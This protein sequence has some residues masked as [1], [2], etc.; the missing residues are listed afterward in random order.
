MKI[1]K[2]TIYKKIFIIYTFII[3]FLIISLDVYF[4]KKVIEHNKE[5]EIYLSERAI[6]DVSEEMRNINSAGNLCIDT[7]YRDYEYIRDVTDFLNMDKIEY[8]KNKL[9]KFSE[10]K[11]SF[12]KGIQYFTESSFYSNEA[13]E[14]ISFIS[15]SRKEI[16]SFN[17]KNQISVKKLEN[18]SL[19]ENYNFTNENN[20]KYVNYSKD[21]RN[22]E[23]LKEEGKVIFTYNLKKIQ[24]ILDKYNNKFDIK[25]LDKRG[26]SKYDSKDEYN[27]VEYPY[28]DRLVIGKVQDNLEKGYYVSSISTSD[29]IVLGRI[30]SKE[31]NTLSISFYTSLMFIDIFVFLIGELLFYFKFKNL[32]VR[33]DN[34]LNVMNKVKEGNVNVSIPIGNEKDEINLIAQNF[35]DMC[36]KL[37]EHIK[38]SYLSE[39]KEKEAELNQKKAEMKALQSQINPHFLYNTLE[40]IRMKAICNEDKEVGKMLYILAFL[41]RSQL[42]EKDVILIKNELDYCNK[43]LEIFK[44]RYDEKFRY[45]VKC[46]EDLLDKQIIK[47]TIQPLIENYFVH[48]IRLESCDNILEM[49]I[50]KEGKVI[51]IVIEDNGSGISKGDLVKLNTKLINR[52]TTGTSIGIIN[53][54]E[55]IVMAYGEAYGIRFDENVENGTKIIMKI[56]CMEG[57]INV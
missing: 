24:N 57:E 6:S 14:S 50:K 5:N 39:I 37:D 40:S 33:L 9:D 47:F 41:F 54:N 32:S 18:V 19:E 51:T 26:L 17:N 1:Q 28:F 27:G 2:A 46:E 38:K 30:N 31:V 12:Y 44:F 45:N 22:P 25:I 49:D 21:I 36:I 52:D 7:M 55:R 29:L 35:N 53:A 56:P 42:K 10:S 16:N 13:L 15:Y 11:N 3:I 23:T 43:Y 20:N 34:I 48:G 4:M 8:L